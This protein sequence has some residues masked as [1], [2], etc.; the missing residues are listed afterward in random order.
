[1]D[2]TTASDLIPVPDAPNYYIALSGDGTPRVFSVARKK[3]LARSRYGLRWRSMVRLPDGRTRWIYLDDPNRPDPAVEVAALEARGA[4][5][6]PGFPDYVITPDLKVY[7]INP[8]MRGPSAS[9]V[10][11]VVQH[12]RCGSPYVQLPGKNGRRSTFSVLKL[13]RKLCLG[14]GG[15]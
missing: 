8:A 14:N 6:L 9:G 5:P 13:H 12:Y 10:T 11:E 15:E 1:M 3:F 2:N 7:R 4:K